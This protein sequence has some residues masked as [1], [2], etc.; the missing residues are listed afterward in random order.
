MSIC[1][2]VGNGIGGA[3]GKF[4]SGLGS[5]LGLGAAVDL[6]TKAYTGYGLL[7]TLSVPY[8][9]CEDGSFATA[10]EWYGSGLKCPKKPETVK[11]QIGRPQKSAK[12]A[13]EAYEEEITALGGAVTAFLGFHYYLE[14]FYGTFSPHLVEGRGSHFEREKNNKTDNLGNVLRY[15]NL[16]ESYG[17]GNNVNFQRGTGNY[18]TVLTPQGTMVK[19]TSNEMISGSMSALRAYRQYDSGYP[20]EVAG[21]F[22]PPLSNGR[23]MFLTYNNKYGFDFFG[24]Q[25]TIPNLPA[26]PPAASIPP[27]PAF[28]PSPPS[29]PENCEMSCPCITPADIENAVKRALG[30]QAFAPEKLVR[31]IGAKMYAA[32]GPSLVPVVPLNLVEAIAAIVATNYMRA[33]Y[34]R[35]PVVM[36]SSLINDDGAGDAVPTNAI[37]NFAE[38]FEWYVKQQDAV[39]GEWPVDIAVVDGAK[40]QPLKFENISEAFAEMTGLMIQG[41]TDADAAVNAACTAALAATKA[42]NSAIIAQKNVE[43]LIRFFGVR[44]G[45]KSIFVQSPITPADPDDRN[46]N[47]RKFLTPSGQNLAYLSDEDP[48]DF[49][50]MCDRILRNTEISRASVARSIDKDG[51]PGDFAR[52][53]RKYDTTESRKEAQKELEKLEQSIQSK[54]PDFKVKIKVDTPV[55]DSIAGDNFV[56]KRLK[57]TNNE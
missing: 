20:N 40:R 17:G 48:F 52:N 9:E 12:D 50:A 16:S 44:T 57:S 24:V 31:E 45:F 6:A 27:P 25:A 42:N 1:K 37:E 46:F 34:G 5:A 15:G 10:I 3:L 19:S 18:E 36:P 41:A 39:Q 32:P 2:G 51:L 33:G 38:W 7:E 43:C 49:Q 28:S 54:N 47:L 30:L 29:S 23:Y 14:Q 11:P 21:F 13:A 4:G 35:Y 55:S 22:M 56:I 26:A 8:I 53:Q